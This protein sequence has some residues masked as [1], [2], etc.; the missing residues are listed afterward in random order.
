MIIFEKNYRTGMNSWNAFVND[1][2]P[3]QPPIDF[4]QKIF[5]KL[6]DNLEYKHFYIQTEENNYIF[7]FNWEHFQQ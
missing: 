7:K 2:E 1:I 4:M 5:K 3:F 6:N